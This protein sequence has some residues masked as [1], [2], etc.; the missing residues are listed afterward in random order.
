MLPFDAKIYCGHKMLEIK[1]V[2]EDTRI[3]ASSGWGETNDTNVK[4][5]FVNNVTDTP[6]LQLTTSK[7]AILRCTPDQ[8]CFGRFNPSLRMYSLYLH[9]RSSLGFRIGLTSDIIHE[10]IG[11]MTANSKSDGK[12]SVTDRIWVIENNPNLTAS[13]FMHKLVMAKYGLPDIPFNSKHKESML[14]DELIKKLFDSI[15]T[16][17]GGKELL[18]DSNMFIEHPH[19]TLKL[20]DSDNPNSNSVHF[21]IFGG[22]E[23]GASGH[24]PHLIQVQGITDPNSAD[25]FKMARRQKSNHGLWYLEVTREDLEEAELFVKTVSN[26]DDL[27]IV[28]KIQLTKK[29]AYYVLP[30]SHLKRG[31]LVPILNSRG[32]IEEDAVNKIEI[33]DYDGPLYDLQVNELHNFITGQWVVMCYTPSTHPKPSFI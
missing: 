9:E 26:L 22:K 20:S 32:V 10:A 33:Y 1:D 24:F 12:R 11:M 23:K 6:L 28:K 8:L 15:D 5:V 16:P 13:T 3:V 14:N 30:A 29:A 2:R 25:Q 21:V 27:E 18:R 4:D 31:M 17:V 7:G 19:L